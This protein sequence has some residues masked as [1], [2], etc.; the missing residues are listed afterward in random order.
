MGEEVGVTNCVFEKVCLSENTIVIV[1][2]ANT[3]VAIKSCML[4]KTE[5]L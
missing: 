4:K 2:S 1:F 5:N 3:A